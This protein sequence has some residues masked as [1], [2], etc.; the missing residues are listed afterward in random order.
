MPLLQENGIAFVARH[1]EAL[2]PMNDAA[3]SLPIFC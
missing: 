3:A 2:L 1:R